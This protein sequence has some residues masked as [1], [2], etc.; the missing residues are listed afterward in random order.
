MQGHEHNSI[1]CHYVIIAS[2]FQL[3]GGNAENQ[4][5]VYLQQ[6]LKSYWVNFDGIL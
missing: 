2:P 4:N 5:T 6:D 3:Q 1:E